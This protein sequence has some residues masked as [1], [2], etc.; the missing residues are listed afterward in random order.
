MMEEKPKPRSIA[1]L[2]SGAFLAAAAGFFGA[3]SGALMTAVRGLFSLQENVV[4]AAV[5]GGPI[6]GIAIA[7]LAWGCLRR[8]GW[9]LQL[10]VDVLGSMIVS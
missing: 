7:V 6:V 10:V 4:L 5:I 8:G 2:V 1:L 9:G 3:M